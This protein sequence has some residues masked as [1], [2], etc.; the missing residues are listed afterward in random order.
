MA[1]K[2]SMARFAKAIREL[3]DEAEAATIRGIQKAALRL[4]G[5]IPEAIQDSKPRPPIDNSVLLNS[6]FTE[7]TDTGAIVGVDAP[8][9]PF[10]EYGVRP[11]PSGSF[12]PAMALADWAYR[13]DIIAVA[14]TQDDFDE[15]L[16]RF[17]IG[18]KDAL[19]LEGDDA[20]IQQEI[21]AAIRTVLAIVR[22]IA[23]KGIEP[24]HF[25]KRS[26]QRF[27]R[28]KI[29]DNAIQAELDKLALK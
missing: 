5:I 20:A 22:S 27:K 26:I 14:L 8:H 2:I 7:L 29:L 3:G 18:S 9:A 13:K 4:E 28:R 15:Y 23:A 11:F 16:A 25:M 21:D 1:Y 17:K 6:H 10:M 12:P 24:R 19:G